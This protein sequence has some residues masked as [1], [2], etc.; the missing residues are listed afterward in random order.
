VSLG[1]RLAYVALCILREPFRRLPVSTS[2]ALGAKLARALEYVGGRRIDFARINLRIAF[3]NWSEAERRSLLRASLE[4]LGRS[5]AELALIQGPR[6]K[7]LFSGIRFEGV[8]HRD[9]ARELSKCGGVIVFT[10]HFGAWELG[11]MATGALGYPLTVVHRA[12]ENPYFEAMARAWREGSGMQTLPQGQAARG[13]VRALR[14][15]DY[16]LMLLDQD[17]PRDEAVFVDFFGMQ[18]A[19]RSAPARLAMRLGVPLL[20]VAVERDGKSARHVVRF[21]EP[22]V[23]QPGGDALA[24]EATSLAINRALEAIVRRHPDHWSWLHRRWRTRP[25]PGEEGP[26]PSR[27][28]CST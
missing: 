20:P 4:N 15:G 13:A 9:R 18:A 24:V 28:R 16:L 27:R 1:Q 3:P 21:F 19:T 6:R 2:L 17:V 10:A 26:Y 11:G 5:L 22:L 14:R 25:R 8:E 7:E 12:F 23:V